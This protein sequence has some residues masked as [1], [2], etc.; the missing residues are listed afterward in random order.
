MT[1]SPHCDCHLLPERKFGGPQQ[2]T[3]D[4][5][6]AVLRAIGGWAG[7]CMGQENGRVGIRMLSI[8]ESSPFD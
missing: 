2:Q 4:A 1:V 5:M 7:K 8:S 6:A 3:R